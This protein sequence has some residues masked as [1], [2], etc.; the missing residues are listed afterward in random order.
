MR[1][2]D[3]ADI[4]R[5]ALGR[6][7]WVG[8]RRNQQVSRRTRR[9]VQRRLLRDRSGRFTIGLSTAKGVNAAETADLNGTRLS[10]SA[11][12]LSIDFCAGGEGA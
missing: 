10:L 3:S 5:S 7:E 9:N 11:G 2:C 12:E 4:L 8:K 1:K 6:M